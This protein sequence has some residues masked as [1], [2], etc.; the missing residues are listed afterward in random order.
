MRPGNHLASA[1]PFVC[2][3]YLASTGWS[4][5]QR[6]G[7]AREAGRVLAIAALSCI[8]VV[9]IILAYAVTRAVPHAVSASAAARPCISLV[10]TI[11]ARV[12][13]YPSRSVTRR[14][15]RRDAIYNA[16]AFHPLERVSPVQPFPPVSLVGNRLVHSSRIASACASVISNSSRPAAHNVSPS[17][18][19]ASATRAARRSASSEACSTSIAS[20]AGTSTS[21]AGNLSRVAPLAISLRWLVAALKPTPIPRYTTNL[22]HTPRQRALVCSSGSKNRNSD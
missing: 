15:S 20:A 17:S 21:G 22:R 13:M 10:L 7:A 2:A 19:A 6:R 16:S 3:M 8:S 12:I 4:I 11:S 5:D 14:R 9:L 18:T 1:C